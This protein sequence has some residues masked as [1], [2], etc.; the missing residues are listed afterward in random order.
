M[1]SH[2]QIKGVSK[3]FA[4]TQALDQVDLD[5]AQ[6]EIHALLGSNGSGKSTLIKIL[7]GVYAA[8]AGTLSIAGTEFD[9]TKHEPVAVR[10]AG[11]HFVHQEPSIFPTLSVAENLGLGRDATRKPLTPVRRAAQRRSAEET[12]E[13]LGIA[14]DPGALA[15]ELRPADQ[16][17]L[18]MAQILQ[19][20]D[21]EGRRVLVLDEPT[22]TLEAGDVKMLFEALRRFA[23]AGQTIVFVSH[24][25]EEVM[26]LADKAT[27]LRDGRN[28]GSLSREE[29]SP[30]ALGELIVGRPFEAYLPSP[31]SVRED[32]PVFEASGVVGPGVEG[33]DLKAYGGEIVG[34]AGLVGSGSSELLRLL[35][36]LAEPE[37][38]EFRVDGEAVTLGSTQAAI[39]AGMAYV[40]ADRHAGG[41]FPELSVRD[42]LSAAALDHYR[43]L[44]G[45]DSRAE[46]RDALLDIE[47][48]KIVAG[49][50]SSLISNLSGGNQ[51]KVIVARWLRTNPRVFL[52]DDPTQGIDVGSRADLWTA[53]EKVMDSGMAVLMTSSDL[54]E[55]ARVCNRI[56]VFRAGRIV[57]EMETTSIG[58]DD[59]LELMHAAPTTE[60]A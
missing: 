46:R 39:R 6:G 2:L 57:A 43:R 45:I 36:G 56:F 27:V 23:A 3:A 31:P 8:D 7:A 51:Q 24:Q 14:A 54:E 53:I 22:S 12:L 60:A 47:K 4:E 50:P 17:L 21:T 28:V 30:A 35:F 1:N 11:L 49:S 55:M 29:F 38:G 5:V 33:V 26:D 41:V 44:K 52:L 19:E 59:L 25:L 58:A 15:A 16:T 42:N 18:A 20:E 13:R 32:M 40:P 34:L 9:L 48:F 37:S 10:Q